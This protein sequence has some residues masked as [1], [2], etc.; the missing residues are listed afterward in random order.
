MDT[1][2]QM[3]VGLGNPGPKYQ[4]TRHNAGADFVLEL[5]RCHNVDLRDDKKFLGA[6]GR[7]TLDGRDVRLLVPSTYMNCSGQSVS[8]MAKF[9][10]IPAG[11]ILVAHDELDLNPGTARLKLGGGHGGHNGLRDTIKA[12]GNNRNFAR[13]RIGIGHPGHADDVVNFVL[14]KASKNEQQLIDQT[15]DDAVRVM[16]QTVAGQWNSAMKELHTK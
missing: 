10:N 5:A 2:I 15:I 14:R 8:A 13:L 6:T 4:R 9:Y 7:V 11:A 1:P 12:L 16:P 3:I